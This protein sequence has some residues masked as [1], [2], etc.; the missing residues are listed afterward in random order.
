MSVKNVSGEW[1]GIET[2]SEEAMIFSTIT[3][4]PVIF[5]TFHQGKVEASAFRFCICSSYF[6]TGFQMYRQVSS[7]TR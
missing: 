2:F 4:R 1:D 6:K 5:A 3:S 7:G